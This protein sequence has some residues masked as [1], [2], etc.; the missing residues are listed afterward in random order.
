MTGPAALAGREIL[1][2]RKSNLGQY[3]AACRDGQARR[4]PA[5]GE[6]ESSLAWQG[7]PFDS[8]RFEVDYVNLEL[9]KYLRWSRD[10]Y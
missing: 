6:H 1:F 5:H 8:E 2:Q 7:E 10:R 4:I 3:A 9:F